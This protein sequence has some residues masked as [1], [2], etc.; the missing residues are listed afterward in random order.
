MSADRIRV[1]AACDPN[2]CDLEQ[3]MVLEH[4]LRKQASLPL[5]IQWMRLSRDPQS[6]WYSDPARG[7]GWRTQTWATPFSGFRWAVP[8]A[9]GFQGRAIYMDTDMIALGDIAELWRTP[10]PAPAVL[11]ARRDRRFTRF[12]VMLWDCARAAAL[13][14]P[15]DR[16]RG[17]ADAHTRLIRRF[18]NETALVQPLDPAFN[19]IDGE[20]LPPERIKLLHYSDMGTQFSHRYAL[21]RLRQENQEHWFDGKVLPHPR[22]DLVRLFD[23]HFEEALASGRR[24]ADYRARDRFGALV[25]KSEKAY[26]GNRV[27]RG[28]RLFGFQPGS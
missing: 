13:L 24:L 4:S 5:D 14:P 6:L 21:P 27:T 9:C 12:C 7:E 10:M 8:A 18:T 1:F 3:Q 11:A 28:R 2:D 20:N 16:L 26:A 23:R 17:Q 22:S 19:N 15:L 25:K